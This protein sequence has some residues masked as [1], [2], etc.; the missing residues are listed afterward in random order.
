[1][2]SNKEKKN[3]FVFAL[4]SINM[5]DTIVSFLL[6]LSSKSDISPK[7]MISLLT[8]VHDAIFNDYKNIMQKVF[9]NCV[10]LLCSFIRE[11]QLLAIQEWPSNSG[12]GSSAVNLIAAQILRIFN[13]PYTQQ[14]YDK[15]LDSI[16]SEL[17]KSD[18]IYVTL[19][20]LKYINKDHISIAISLL[21]RLV[22]NTESSKTF[23]Q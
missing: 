7:G 2:R 11:N 1:M 18:I 16:S 12:G 23:A 19:N 5:A 10:K 22:F 14:I 21:S 6:N 3:D 17:S 15:E 4:N 9:K 8:F 20:V 13:L